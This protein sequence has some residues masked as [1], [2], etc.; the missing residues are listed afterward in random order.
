M[1]SGISHSEDKQKNK[2]KGWR[3]INGQLQSQQPWAF[4]I[5]PLNLVLKEVKCDHFDKVNKL[6]A[7]RMCVFNVLF[8][9]DSLKIKTHGK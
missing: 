4:L 6:T 9:T 8:Q 5:V 7:L 2:I 1:P 3:K